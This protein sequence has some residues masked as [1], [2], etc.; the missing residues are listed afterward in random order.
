[1]I[2]EI[3][4]MLNNIITRTLSSCD[5]NNCDEIC[6]NYLMLVANNCPVVFNNEV[7]L[8]L[9]NTLFKICNNVEEQDSIF[10]L[11]K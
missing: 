10:Y 7:Y 2:T 6:V 8:E 5:Y 11:D 3:S 4:C 1:M 9:W